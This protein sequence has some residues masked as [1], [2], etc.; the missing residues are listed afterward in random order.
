MKQVHYIVC[1]VFVLCVIPRY[2]IAEERVVIKPFVVNAPSEYSYLGR[3]LPNVIASRIGSSAVIEESTDTEVKQYNLITGSVTVLGKH[4]SIDIRLE[5]I[6]GTVYIYPVTAVVDTILPEIE[7]I[8]PAMQNNI[9]TVGHGT[10]ESETKKMGESQVGFSGTEDWQNATALSIAPRGLRIADLD[11]NGEKEYVILGERELLIYK[12]DGNIFKEQ[13]R[14][15]FKGKEEAKYLSVAPIN[16]KEIGILVTVMI[17]TRASYSYIFIYTNEKLEIVRAR[18]SY[19]FGA[20]YNATTKEYVPLLQ[21]ITSYPTP[22][23]SSGVYT[24]TVEDKKIRKGERITLPN[25]GNV[26]NFTTLNIQNKPH[27]LVLF[28]G[29]ETFSV[30]TINPLTLTY[31]SGESY[32]STTYYLPTVPERKVEGKT[33]ALQEL[34]YIPTHFVHLP[35]TEQ[36][37]I[38]FS[39]ALNRTMVTTAYRTYSKYVIEAIRFNEQSFQVTWTSAVINA[40]VADFDINVDAKENIEL[41]ILVT[42]TP[43]VASFQKQRSAL[44]FQSIKKGKE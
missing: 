25:Q 3:A 27:L 11:K 23:F 15:S 30:Y 36:P 12:R 38:L 26:F 19:L 42:Y 35:N 29:L 10:K 33:S 5:T 2:G 31:K 37:I 40:T 24:F 18:E 8:I 20:Y 21:E 16:E 1:M 7:T 34:Y 6:N 9:K 32:S 14:Y 22:Y 39:N 28:P 43:V 41:F 17:D 44:L 4:V 13:A